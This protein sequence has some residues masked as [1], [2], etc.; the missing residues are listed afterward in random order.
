MAFHNVRFPTEI[1]YGS[2]GGPGHNT[3][4]LELESGAEERN[5][6]WGGARRRYNA[7]YGLKRD[8]DIAAVAAFAIARKGATHSFRL[9]DHLDFTTNADHISA[10]GN[11]DVS[12]GTLNGSNNNFQLRKAYISGPTTEYRN[13]TLPV[14]GQT[15]ISYSSDGINFTELTAGSDFSVS[16]LGV[17]T[18]SGAVQALTGK[19]LYYGGEFDVPVRFSASVDQLLS[20]S[21][22]D[23]KNGVIPDIDM[24]EV[25][26]NLAIPDE[27]LYGGAREISS[28]VDILLTPLDGRVQVVSMTATSKKVKLPDPTNLPT[29]GPYFM[30]MN[31][32][33]NTYEIT[34]HTGTSLSPALNQTAGQGVTVCLSVD[35]SGNKI[36]YAI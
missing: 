23:Y 36:W 16:T 26:D 29:G 6:R 18:V 7:K 32:G 27:F 8:T 14:S 21:V 3:A 19:T 4:I 5:A 17:V 20:M 12:I 33:S 25:A 22:E 24:I 28:A 13:I 9:K 2:S 30:I 31:G 15:R 35:G 11:H 1:A 10:H 34:T